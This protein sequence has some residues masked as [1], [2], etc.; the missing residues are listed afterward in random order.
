MLAGD[1]GQRDHDL[2]G[3]LGPIAGQLGGRLD[4]DDHVVS[5]DLL[6]QQ[7]RLPATPG[8]GAA[9]QRATDWDLYSA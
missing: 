7:A 9:C 2:V 3:Q 6:Q 1:R 5:V 8:F 4:A